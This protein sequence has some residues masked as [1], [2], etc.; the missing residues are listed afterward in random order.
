[1]STTDRPHADQHVRSVERAADILDVL[2]A[3]A[4]ESL[5]SIAAQV[6][7]AKSAVH[8]TLQT[9]CARGLVRSSGAG[10]ARRYALGLR[11]AF[12]GEQ[13]LARISIREV[14]LPFLRELTRTTGLTSRVVIRAENHA[15]AVG[16]V[17]IL[18]GQRFKLH[19][20]QREYLHSTA[21]GKAILSAL[22]DSEVRRAMVAMPMIRRTRRTVA[23]L[24]ELFADIARTRQR[25]WAVDDEEDAAGVVCFGAAVLDHSARP[26][27]GISVTRAKRGLR[28][29]DAEAI[30]LRV[31]ECAAAVSFA[32]GHVEETGCPA[33]LSVTSSRGTLDSG[34]GGRDSTRPRS[35]GRAPTANVVDSARGETYPVR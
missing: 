32:L 27:G 33:R 4:E 11:L 35:V 20:G 25:G 18:D 3:S 12:L 29:A 22:P 24:D 16:W 28:A 30:G 1:M 19:M 14:A 17:D 23:S 10:P 5:T 21:A 9:L 34:P 6:G 15:I 13:A 7:G 2:A 26:A 8:A 31:A